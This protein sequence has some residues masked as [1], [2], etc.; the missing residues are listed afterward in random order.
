MY[1]FRETLTH[2]FAIETLEHIYSSRET[3]EHLY[4]SRETLEYIYL[5]RDTLEHIY[6]QEIP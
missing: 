3:L 1:S 5:S 2:I 6:R 4:S